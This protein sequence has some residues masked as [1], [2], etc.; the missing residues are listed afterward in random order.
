MRLGRKILLLPVVGLL[1][2]GC[3]SSAQIAKNHNRSTTTSVLATSSST[4]TLPSKSV[5]FGIQQFAVTPTTLDSSG[6]SYDI[7]YFVTGA[8]NCE[9]DWTFDVNG[10]TSTATV[11][12]SCVGMSASAHRSFPIARNTTQYSTI[13]RIALVATSWKGASQS[14]TV[15]VVELSSGGG[16]GKS[17]WS[18]V[19]G[20]V[21]NIGSQA[22][23]VHFDWESWES[24]GFSQSALTSEI[25]SLGAAVSALD[26]VPVG[27][28][29]A[30]FSEA[31]DLVSSVYA[32]TTWAENP[33]QLH[34]SDFVAISNAIS[35]LESTQ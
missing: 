16:G 28:S 15:S 27:A 4:T 18:T 14:R 7:S 8:A 22:D 20:T 10:F 2:S 6:G 21:S 25:Q 5:E 34:E 3:G 24:G 30:E 32:V 31:S 12:L 17:W 13:S 11:P 33:S 29:G 26:P 1:L 35:N 9:V 23:Q 19:Q